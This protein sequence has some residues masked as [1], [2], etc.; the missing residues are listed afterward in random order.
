L[1]VMSVISFCMTNMTNK[2]KGIF[3][4][5]EKAGAKSWINVSHVSHVVD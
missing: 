3:W 1:L 2:Y 5:K 4:E